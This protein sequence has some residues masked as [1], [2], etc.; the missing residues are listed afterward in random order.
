M[1]GCFEDGHAVAGLGQ[2]KRGGQS[3]GTAA[4]HGDLLTVGFPA[5]DFG[6]PALRFRVFDGEALQG[7]YRNRLIHQRPR[8]FALAGMIAQPSADALERTGGGDSLESFFKLSP[9]DQS[10]VGL[11]RHVVGTRRHARSTQ[12]RLD[13]G[14]A[15]VDRDVACGFDG[16]HE[17]VSHIAEGFVAVPL[18]VV[19]QIL[20]QRCEQLEAVQEDARAD[21]DEVRPAKRGLDRVLGMDDAA[22]VEERSL[23]S[24][25]FAHLVSVAQSQG[26]E[27]R[28]AVAAH[29]RLVLEVVNALQRILD[30]DVGNAQAVGRSADAVGAGLERR[31]CDLGN[32]SALGRQLDEQRNAD[33]FFDDFGDVSDHVG[34]AAQGR[35]AEGAGAARSAGYLDVV[36]HVRTAEVQLDG[37]CS[38]VLELFGHVRPALQA[39]LADVGDISPDDQLFRR[40]PPLADQFKSLRQAEAFLAGEGEGLV[41]L[42]PAVSRTAVN[43]RRRIECQLDAAGAPA[44]LFG[45]DELLDAHRG[46]S[47]GN[48]KR[49]AEL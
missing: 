10:H 43:I 35:A 25:E 32:V 33:G 14:V 13:L 49:V 36:A 31:L 2:I 37:V 27:P 11:N 28:A 12:V 18:H 38:D 17:H 19:F 3:S 48:V 24:G 21:A 16:R 1:F 7:F 8:A 6:L 40:L 47:T 20:H 45:L 26:F 15:F 22:V 42:E 34:V 4:D 46:R 30:I 9:G 29:R 23:G 44:A 39:T 41:I 5:L